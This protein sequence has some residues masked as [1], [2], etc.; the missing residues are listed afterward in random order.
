[1]STADKMLGLVG[2]VTK[3]WG[4]QRK[5]EIRSARASVNRAQYLRPSRT[6]MK[7]VVWDHIDEAYLA[8]SGGGTLPA[9][10]RQ[11]FYKMRPIVADITGETLRDQ[12]FCQTL[13]PDYMEEYGVDW[14]VV[15]DARGHLIEPHTRRSIGIGTLGVRGYLG[16]MHSAAA[17]ELALRPPRIDTSGPIGR[18]SAVLFVEKEGFFPLFEEVKLAER[19]DIALMSTKGMSS[20]AGREL[21]RNI[22]VPILALHDFDKA[23]FSIVG[24][25]Q[26]ATR[27]FDMTGVEVIDLGIRGNDIKDW[28]LS[29]EPVSYRDNVY[30]M[31]RNLRLNG[32]T[33]DEIPLLLNQ[34]VE[35]NEFASD[36][37][38]KWIE[39]KLVEHDVEKVLPD[40]ATLAKAY[41][42]E[43]IYREVRE[44]VKAAI[45]KYI[46][47]AD[48]IDVP[49]DLVSQIEVQFELDD[50][51]SWDNAIRQ[52][53][54]NEID[55]YDTDD[56][57]DDDDL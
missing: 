6:S 12:Y 19:F 5:R 52:I 38:V 43:R 30:A 28:D 51:L 42:H 50:T 31:E 36:D 16:E 2:G 3:K 17:R 37:L 44:Q 35:L 21:M 22:G 29:F 9:H 34:R 57:D 7:S 11:I 14:N 48:D 45:D 20:T 46:G 54:G 53:V 15:F 49:D 10:A 47:A 55:A 32:A 39:S 40:A 13:L 1:M 8:A 23:G 26:R 41:R 27:R 18:F 33:G 56:E 24:T 25:L 4:K